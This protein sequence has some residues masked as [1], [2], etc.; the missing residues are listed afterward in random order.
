MANI[1]NSGDLQAQIEI[2]NRDTV[3]LEKTL[4][5]FTG[6]QKNVPALS[7]TE[8]E[9][10]DQTNVDPKTYKEETALKTFIFNKKDEIF[11]NLPNNLTENQINIEANSIKIRS[12]ALILT[13]SVK[14]TNTSDS[15]LIMPTKI[16]LT[17]FMATF[18]F[19]DE[20]VK[21][22]GLA[23][24][25]AKD[26]TE[27]RLKEIVVNKASEIFDTVP[28]GGVSK[29]CLLYTSDAADDC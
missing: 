6:F 22:S 23:N 26:I 18:A 11:K 7:G 24:E 10:K 15:D 5:T 12:G 2:K 19:K 17:G 13:L 25:P 4:I 3:L 16:K 27:E 20:T 28:E 14:A 8:I 29:D 1:P 21:L 9:L